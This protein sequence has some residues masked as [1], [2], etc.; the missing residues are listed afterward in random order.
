LAENIENTH[1]SQL[2]GTNHSHDQYVKK[3][4]ENSEMVSHGLII[5]DL[6]RVEDIDRFSRK[7]AKFKISGKTIVIQMSTK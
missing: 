3:I 4:A 5:I 6:D 1:L 2:G 7:C